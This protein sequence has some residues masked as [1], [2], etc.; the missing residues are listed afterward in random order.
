M[1]MG[2]LAAPGWFWHIIN[3]VLDIGGVDAANTFLNDTTIGGTA[4]VWR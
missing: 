3:S 2:V 1:P 4:V